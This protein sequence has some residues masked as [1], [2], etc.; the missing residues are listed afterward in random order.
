MM[1]VGPFEAQTHVR[2][3][4]AGQ[5]VCGRDT[6]LLS[7]GGRQGGWNVSRVCPNRTGTARRGVVHVREARRKGVFRFSPGQ[8]AC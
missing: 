8:P 4:V 2:A 5:V 7:E 6:K 3:P 1:L